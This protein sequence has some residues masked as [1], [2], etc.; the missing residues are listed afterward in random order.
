LGPSEDQVGSFLKGDFEMGALYEKS[1]EI[2]EIIEN[3]KKEREDIFWYVEP[4]RI[5][6]GLRTDK[7]A[8]ARQKAVLKIMGLSG[9]KTLAT[10]KRYI[11]HG[12]G[13]M[14]HSLSYA[15]KIAHVASQLKRIKHPSPGEEMENDDICNGKLQ[16]VDLKDWKT[17][18]ENFGSDWSDTP[19]G[20]IP[21]ILE[22]KD[23]NV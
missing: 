3:L 1:E 9:P 21:N 2:I 5:A 16:D 7:V 10:D 23:L 8:P 17:F 4:D 20:D 15:K 22:D 12:Y 11:I 18:V 6:A 13:S 14:W 19:T